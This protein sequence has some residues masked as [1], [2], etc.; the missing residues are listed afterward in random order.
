[1]KKI[2]L[3][4]IAFFIGMMVGMELELG[5]APQKKVHIINLTEREILLY[6]PAIDSKGKGVIA[7]LSTKIRPGSGDVLVRINDVLPGLDTQ[8][9]ARTA[10]EVAS[11][12][13]ALN[14]TDIDVVFSIKA[15]AMVVEGPSAGA[16]MAVSTIAAIEGRKINTNVLITGGIDKN[17]NIKSVGAISE[18]AKV[19]KEKNATLL[20]VPPN[21]NYRVQRYGAQE[22]CE[23]RDGWEYCRIDF[24]ARE[25]SI[26]EII[27]IEIKEVENISEAMRYFYES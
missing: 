10:V 11:N 12:Y 19:A 13:T 21:Q 17:G 9:S 1:M 14:F 25:V 26:G 3:L 15:D 5:E 23:E 16:A 20:L 24:V 27:G 4:V 6:L 7:E 18:K 22:E 8:R 2:I